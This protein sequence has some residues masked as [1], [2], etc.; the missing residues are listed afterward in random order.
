MNKNHKLPYTLAL[1]TSTPWLTLA[2]GNCTEIIYQHCS[3]VIE[4]HSR[5]L[6]QSLEEM[7]KKN[8]FL[9]FPPEQIVVGRGPG[10][11]TGIKIANIT[12]RT[13]AYS[14]KCSLYG[15]STLEMLAYQGSKQVFSDENIT[16]I[17]VIL[18]KKNQV[19]WSEFQPGFQKKP[20]Y[21][22]KIQI[23]SA[24]DI[25]N[26]YSLNHIFIV[27]PWQELYNFFQTHHFQC[28]PLHWSQPNA[29]S[30]IELIDIRQ[31]FLQSDT[32]G[33]SGENIQPLYGSR[34][35]EYE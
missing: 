31:K 33:F 21:K 8:L 29:I 11:F 1:D 25:I 9:T 17:P 35:F 30:L 26:R 7:Q 20:E 28:L 2:L 34:V 23:G 32:V 27:T 18:H 6:I 5:V 16:I 15:F 24:A 22:I 19:F 4:D 14:F 12:G 13:L 10:S 3:Q